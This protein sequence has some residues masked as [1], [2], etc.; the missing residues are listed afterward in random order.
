[1]RGR[2][3]NLDPSEAAPAWPWQ[4]APGPRRHRLCGECGPP[5]SPT[6]TDVPGGSAS[7][8]LP[9]P[10]GQ[11]R[12]Q[13]GREREGGLRGACV[14]AGEGSCYSQALSGRLE[15]PTRMLRRDSSNLPLCREKTGPRV[16]PRQLL[17]PLALPRGVSGIESSQSLSSGMGF[18][19]TV[20]S[21]SRLRENTVEARSPILF[22]H[23]SSSSW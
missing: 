15:L 21:S 13:M 19:N 5:G 12:P 4:T 18:K 2:N 23:G 1:M 8:P 7:P 20:T 14:C 6:R 3:W 16:R 9:G 11:R 10:A 22:P 17:P